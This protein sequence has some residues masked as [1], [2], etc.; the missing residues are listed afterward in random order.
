MAMEEIFKAFV[1][2]VR[3]PLFFK[4]HKEQLILA[5]HSLGLGD[6]PVNPPDN[7]QLQAIE[8]QK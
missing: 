3:D 5:R 6:G 4:T 7:S 8:A 1:K 2:Q